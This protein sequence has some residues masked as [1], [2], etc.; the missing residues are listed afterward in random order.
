MVIMVFLFCVLQVTCLL[1][2]AHLPSIWNLGPKPC[3]IVY[4]CFLSSVLQILKRIIFLNLHSSA[5]CI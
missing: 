5:G 3:S 2:D 4:C 1:L